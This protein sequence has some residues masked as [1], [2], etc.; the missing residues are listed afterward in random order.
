VTADEW[1]NAEIV[2]TLQRIEKKLEDLSAHFVPRELHEQEQKEQDNRHSELAKW[3]M[4]L[5]ASLA[6]TQRQMVTRDSARWVVGTLVVLIVG[7]ATVV[8]TVALH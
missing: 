3:V 8:T 1:T 6:R 4:D 5:D 2:R 7:L